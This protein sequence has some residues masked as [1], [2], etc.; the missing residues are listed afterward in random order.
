MTLKTGGGM[1]GTQQKAPSPGEALLAALAVFLGGSNIQLAPGLTTST[2]VA[3]AL[4][5]LWLPMALR[6]RVSR[7]FTLLAAL[8]II[9]GVVLVGLR[10]GF[11]D[12][13]IGAS[14][15]MTAWF[16]GVSSTAAIVIWAHR[17]LSA[18]FV[19]V[20]FALGWM[21]N[22]LYYFEQATANPW[23]YAFS[24]PVTLLVLA[25][26]TR[27]AFA[28][29]AT[30]LVALAIVGI[31]LDSRIY[32][33]FCLFTLFF[34]L[35]SK[36][37]PRLVGASVRTRRSIAILSV[38]GLALATYVIGTRMLTSG[39]FGSSM[40]YRA[41]AQISEG[42]NLLFGGRPEWFASSALMISNPAGYGP[43]A[44]PSQ[45]DVGIAQSGLSALHIQIADNQYFTR[46][47]FGNEFRLHSVLAD[48]WVSW[49]FAGLATGI[50]L[51]LLLV[52][53][54]ARFFTAGNAPTWAVFLVIGGVW[55]LF[56]GPLYSNYPQIVF[57]VSV[58]GLLRLSS[59]RSDGT[60]NLPDVAFPP[61][62][63]NANANARK[64][65]NWKT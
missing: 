1:Q 39:L 15:G 36:A 25:L 48:L 2:A 30:L 12:F 35:A 60:H 57:S 40:Q 18:R 53:S 17:F 59:G 54:L 64:I 34:L 44:I 20:M 26:V 4:S 43:G 51:A 16:F 32:A 46:Y 22:S 65:E 63:P 10:S 11:A 6:L 37:W 41:M 47:M 21:A 24:L 28:I 58:I 49:G 9:N 7:Q 50:F 52:G 29:Q 56:F 19:V 13:N 62:D 31:T 5:P 42:G 27:R 45:D 23:K 61:T 14:L 3:V 33:A 8:C 55:F 38:G